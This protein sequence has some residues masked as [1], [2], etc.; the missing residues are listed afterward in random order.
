MLSK[1]FLNVQS[2]PRFLSP[3]MG[4]KMSDCVMRMALKAVSDDNT[5]S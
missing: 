4:A 5:F 1:A 3:V 2:S